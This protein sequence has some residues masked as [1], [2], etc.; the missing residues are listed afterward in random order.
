MTA[1][2]PAIFGIGLVGS[3]DE[4]LMATRVR[5]KTTAGMDSI[6]ALKAEC[7]ERQKRVAGMKCVH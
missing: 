2:D 1:A 7:R 5:S 4:T 3:S 6:Q